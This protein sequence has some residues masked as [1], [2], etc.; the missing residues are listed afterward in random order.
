VRFDLSSAPTASD[1]LQNCFV[2]RLLS[3][4]GRSMRYFSADPAS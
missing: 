3:G 1:F 2:D 4:V